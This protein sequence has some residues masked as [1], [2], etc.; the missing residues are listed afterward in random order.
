MG[1]PDNWASSVGGELCLGCRRQR[2]AEAAI[3]TAP[4]GTSV[5]DRAKLGR[6]GM[7]EF[8]VRRTPN[9]TDNSIARSCGASAAAV[10]AA[11]R[12]LNL[13]AGP[14]PGSDRD[15]TSARSLTSA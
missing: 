13:K 11:R 7:V 1:L 5:T 8:E 12:R 3:D 4:S 2:A 6:A 14:P 10:A 9:L 15:R